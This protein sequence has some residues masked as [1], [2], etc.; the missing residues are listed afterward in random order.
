MYKPG[1]FSVSAMINEL[2]DFFTKDHTQFETECKYLYHKTIGFPESIIIPN[3]I[4]NLGY[5][6]HARNRAKERMKGVFRVLPTFVR[7]TPENLIEIHTD[8]NRY[9][10]KAVVKLHYDTNR[11]II[12]V[13]DIK[14]PQKKAVVVTLYYNAKNHSFETLDKSKF[15]KPN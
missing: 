1:E 10:K 7:L 9:I 4:F 2:E 15:T 14:Y 3:R 11:D 8:D 6:N 12:L 13:L 5:T